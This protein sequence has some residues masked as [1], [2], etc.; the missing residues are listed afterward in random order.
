VS[1]ARRTA[2]GIG[3]AGAITGAAA[4]AAYGA[5]RLAARRVRRGPD[6]PDAERL[7]A[8][9]V[10]VSQRIASFDGGTINVVDREPRA[11]ARQPVTFVLSHGV[12]LSV[13][14]WLRQLDTLPAAG[15]RTVAFD[16][17]GHGE[18]VLGDAGHSV[19][20]LGNDID[21]VLEALDLERVV[22]VG[23]SMGGIAVQSY[24]AQHPDAA[25]RR[26]AGL[27]LLSTLART[28]GGSQA[29]QLNQLVERVTRRTPDTT[30][31][32]ASPNLGLV[33]ARLGF[34]RDA[35]PSHVELVR[36]M[37]LACGADTRT[38]APRSLIGFDLTPTLER[39]ALPT[40]IVV[41]TA[42]VI[43]PPYEARRMARAIPGSR[44]EVFE[45]GGHML[46]LER[47][48]DLDALLVE[49]ASSLTQDGSQDAR[50]AGA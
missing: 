40:L 26:L 36:Q 34:G 8:E 13:R 29:A 22:L 3:I 32:W 50:A 14:T 11:A 47:T 5:A 9:P 1:R 49:F 38:A 23:H 7:L 10:W 17:R 20:N 35:K 41:G 31:I 16:H 24:I 21:T 19:E 15:F 27:V 48:A 25:K 28:P 33:L 39:I 6:D 44:L 18:S 43:T 4:G 42:D 12:T 30:R 37:M 45:G 2:R 46:M